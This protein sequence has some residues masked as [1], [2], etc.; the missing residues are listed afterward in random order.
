[1]TSLDLNEAS[2]LI[3]TVVQDLKTKPKV[4]Y[5]VPENPRALERVQEVLTRI[6]KY[7]VE[8]SGKEMTISSC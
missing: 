6:F 3:Y 4:S 8:I 1:M 7:S 5:K 2:V